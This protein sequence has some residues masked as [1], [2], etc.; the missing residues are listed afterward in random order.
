MPVSRKSHKT[1]NAATD[2]EHLQ[3]AC[4]FLDSQCSAPA[5]QHIPLAAVARNFNVS[6][7]TL[8]RR[9]KRLNEDPCTAHESQQALSHVQE[10]VLLE[11]IKELS[12][13][14]EPLSKRSLRQTIE[15]ITGGR[16]Q[17]G[18]NWIARFLKRH[19]SIRTASVT[20]T[21]SSFQLSGSI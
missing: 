17:T 11:W 14:S 5:A 16:V 9:Y 20:Q 15:Y 21:Q 19:P 10:T 18:K 13:Q 8:R 4:D 6:Y 1:K 7:H 3:L 2:N 12:A